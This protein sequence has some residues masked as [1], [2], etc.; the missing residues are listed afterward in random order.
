M[1]QRTPKGGPQGP[2]TISLP[3]PNIKGAMTLEETL[4]GRR[5]VREFAEHT[6]S[7]AEVGQLLWAGS[8][9]TGGGAQYRTHPSAG[10]LHPLEVYAVLPAG[11]YHYQPQWHCMAL[12]WEGDARPDLAKAALGQWF[13]A[14]AGCTV[15]IAAVYQRT[16]ARYGER[17]R[18]RYVPMDAAHAAQNILLQAVA[19]GL[20]AVPVGAFDDEAVRRVLGLPP[21]EVAL[22]LIPVGKP[23][24]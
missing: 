6:A 18:L 24:G 8:G 2:A 16:M 19:L 23:R 10:A 12:T 17:G 3:R 11:I 1:G 21:E 5:S 22:Y 7:L 15:A 20:G 13:I 4:A 9:V 14:Q